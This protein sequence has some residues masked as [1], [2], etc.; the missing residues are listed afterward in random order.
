MLTLL[1][2]MGNI[3]WGKTTFEVAVAE[4]IATRDIREADSE[5][6]FAVMLKSQLLTLSFGEFDVYSSPSQIV[7]KGKRR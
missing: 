2:D 4:F 3:L 6:W 7:D 1:S 5:I